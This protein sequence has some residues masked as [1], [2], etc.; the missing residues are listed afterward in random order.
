MSS[1]KYTNLYLGF[2]TCA[3]WL[4][5]A[6]IW[7]SISQWNLLCGK[8]K[9]LEHNGN[10]H[11]LHLWDDWL[12][13]GPFKHSRQIGLVRVAGPT[14]AASSIKT[15]SKGSM[16]R[17]A[18]KYLETICLRDFCLYVIWPILSAPFSSLLREKNKTTRD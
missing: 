17:V 4:H 12:S 7:H 14:T 1:V 13:K 8:T 5:L 9:Q 18:T 10:W 15:N 11:P 2:L 16:S 3:F 6:R